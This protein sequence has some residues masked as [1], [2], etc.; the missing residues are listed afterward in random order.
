MRDPPSL[1]DDDAITRAKIAT[2]KLN[3]D[4]MAATI[5][6]ATKKTKIFP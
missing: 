6:I 3:E 2:D 5:A 1:L 4:M